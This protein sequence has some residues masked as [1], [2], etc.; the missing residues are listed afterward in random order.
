MDTR[1]PDDEV[2]CCQESPPEAGDDLGAVAPPSLLDRREWR[3]D[4]VFDEADSPM[5]GFGAAK[6]RA[7]ITTP[8]PG[9]DLK[10]RK[11]A[12]SPGATQ[13]P[14]LA[15]VVAAHATVR[16][17]EPQGKSAE[18]RL[19]MLTLLNTQPKRILDAIALAFDVLKDI[20]DSHRIL[21]LSSQRATQTM[22]KFDTAFSN[23]CK[24]SR[25]G[26]EAKAL[27]CDMSTH[28]NLVASLMS[29][30]P[31]EKDRSIERTSK[32]KRRLHTS[33]PEAIQDLLRKAEA[34]NL[35]LA[36]W[37][38]QFTHEVWVDY[39]I[40]EKD[41]PMLRALMTNQPPPPADDTPCIVTLHGLLVRGMP[42]HQVGTIQ[43]LDVDVA[44]GEAHFE[45]RGPK[46]QAS[47]G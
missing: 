14:S 27:L 15:P 22:G 7:P 30:L 29:V 10:R 19:A 44:I 2:R 5:L 43:Q 33:R 24:N 23:S 42:D 36:L 6:R 32:G 25:L 38:Y 35:N 31:K 18:A 37:F 20:A 16:T 41:F 13:M 21:A 3:D 1:L 45:A 46:H 9:A 28:C 47:H 4:D 12:G 40:D 17:G 11:A 39:A 26:E 8:S 34:T